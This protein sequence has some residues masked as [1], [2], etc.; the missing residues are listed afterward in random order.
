MKPTRVEDVMTCL[1]VRL[2]PT[3]TVYEAAARLAQN[4]VSGAPVV[5]EGRVVGIVTEAD[6]MRSAVLGVDKAGSTMNILGLFLK[7]H[8]L[9][10]VEDARVSSVMSEAVISIAPSA[11]LAHAAYI[12][13]RHGVKRL[14]VADDERHLVGI[15][16]RSDLIA[17]IA[18]PEALRDGDRWAI[19][20]R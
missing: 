12:M 11:S 1:V 16:S 9:V 20:A 7:G 13:E 15:L 8:I 6:L 3:D 4:N 10:P 17:A 14:P 19:T 5:K 18:H 2:Y